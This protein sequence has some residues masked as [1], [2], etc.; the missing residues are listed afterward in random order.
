MAFRTIEEIEAVI[1]DRLKAYRLELNRNQSE[2][3]A[4]A[5]ISQ[6]I[7]RKLENGESCTMKSFIS[8]V[9]ALQLEDWFETLAP[10]AA[11]NPF[12]LVE[13]KPRQRARKKKSAHG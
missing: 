8:V 3:A 4:K 9:K 5:G 10:I 6:S 7:L 2:L 13:D 11:T 1:G 12:L